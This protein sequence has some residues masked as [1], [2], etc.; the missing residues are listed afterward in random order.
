MPHDPN[1]LAYWF[2]R[3]E[4]GGV[5]VP[6]TELISLDGDG[7]FAWHSLGEE[8][9]P[10]GR[11]RVLDS[12]VE[13]IAAAIVKIQNGRRVPVFLRTGHTSNKHDWER[14][15]YLSPEAAGDAGEIK[16]HVLALVEFSE[17]AGF[18]GLPFRD[19]VVREYLPLPEGATVFTAYRGM[20]VRREFRCFVSDEIA[21]DPA[22]RIEPRSPELVCFHPYW[23]L[24][25][26]RA[27]KPADPEWYAK[28]S[29]L[30][31]WHDHERDAI[32]DIVL[33]AAMHAGPV[34]LSERDKL[35]GLRGGWSID[36]LETSHGWMVTDMARAGDSWHWETCPRAGLFDA[37]RKP[38]AGPVAVASPLPSAREMVERLVN[39]G[40]S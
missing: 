16:S 29:K 30:M 22:R 20:P 18:I 24:E 3:I 40:E 11:R 25:A 21:G 10:R 19:W 17:T 13:R 15:C 12:L 23:P 36:V 37:D 1:N 14:T 5:P 38:A 34:P 39:G 33:R 28:T 7:L 2:P 8:S 4:A 9:E 6:R 32:E 27:G 35:A 31:A 26:V